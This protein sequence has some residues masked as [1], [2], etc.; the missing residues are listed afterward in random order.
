[1][2]ST[3]DPMEENIIR[4]VSQAIARADS[5]ALRRI[6]QSTNLLLTRTTHQSATH[7]DYPKYATGR[8]LTPTFSINQ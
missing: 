5:P 3:D 2:S 8:T 7:T 1:M 6:N 4:F